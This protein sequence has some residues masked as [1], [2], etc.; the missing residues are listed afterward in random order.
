MESKISSRAI[1]KMLEHLE[2][3]GGDIDYIDIQ[4]TR[5]EQEAPWNTNEHIVTYFSDV[6]LAV[7]R[8]TK[9]GV[10]SDEVELLSNALFSIKTSG[11]MEYALQE[12]DKKAKADQTWGKQRLILAKS[13]LIAESIKELKR[14]KQDSDP[15]TK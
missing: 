12:W 5:K 6:Q 13:M 15:Q 3:R 1:L 11:K 9:A 14:S 2:S 7:K 4:E 10:T 8:L